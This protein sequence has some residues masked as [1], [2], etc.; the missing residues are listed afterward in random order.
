MCLAEE[1]VGEVTSRNALPSSNSIASRVPYLSSREEEV[2]CLCLAK[3]GLR[4]EVLLV[5]GGVGGRGR[6][7]G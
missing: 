1:V 7:A 2:V 6:G 5:S 4:E 3:G